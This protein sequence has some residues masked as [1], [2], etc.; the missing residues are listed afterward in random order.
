MLKLANIMYRDELVNHTK[1]DFINYVPSQLDDFDKE[2]PK[3]FVGWNY[4]KEWD[5]SLFS[6]LSILNKEISKNI[7]YWE[8]SFNENKAQHVSG[9]EMFIRNAPYY[10]FRDKYKYKNVDP[11]FENFE[12]IQDL[13]N[14]IPNNVEFVYNYKNEGLY[15]LNEDIIYG[16]DLNMYEFFNI[17][18]D[19]II[20]SV[21]SEA[22]PYAV[23]LEGETYQKHYKNYPNFEELKRYLVVL[24]SKG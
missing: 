18:K 24:L 16:I 12:T 15:F 7:A 13:K 3:L 21:V 22:T 11:I 20:N 8:F 1:V 19:E 10:Y 14:I 9:V 5:V 23:D 2:I 4:L 6:D 17:E